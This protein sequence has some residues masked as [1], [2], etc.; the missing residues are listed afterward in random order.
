VTNA[1]II[2]FEDDIRYRAEEA[3][4]FVLSYCKQ[5]AEKEVPGHQIQQGAQHSRA[6]APPESKRTRPRVP[7]KRSP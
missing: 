1:A 6:C 3:V 7:R 2:E 5:I 4:A